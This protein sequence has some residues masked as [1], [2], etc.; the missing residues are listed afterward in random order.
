MSLEASLGMATKKKIS[1]RNQI[2]N[3]EENLC[4]ESNSQVIRRVPSIYKAVKAWVNKK[5]LQWQLMFGLVTNNAA[6]AYR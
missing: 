5:E 6:S 2:L 3:K 1:A 4:K